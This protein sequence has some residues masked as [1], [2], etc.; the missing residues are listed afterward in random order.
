VINNSLED[1]IE[2]LTVEKDGITALVDGAYYSLDIG[3]KTR[4]KGI[5]IVPNNLVGGGKNSNCDKFEIDEKEHLVKKCPFGHKPIST[6][7][8]GSY[9]AHFDKKYCSNCPF[10]KDCLVVKQKKSYLFKVSETKL[11]RSQLIAKMG[12]PSI[13]S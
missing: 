11:H 4:A 2:K 6:F 8:K 1:T 12:T 5:K 3:N 10:H 9:R 7:K 13:K